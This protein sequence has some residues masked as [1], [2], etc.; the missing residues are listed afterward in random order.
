MALI[1][2]SLKGLATEQYCAKW[3][4][5]LNAKKSKNVSFGKKHSLAILKLDGKDIEWVDSWSNLGVTIK[6]HSSFNCCIDDKVKAFYRCAKTQCK[7]E[8][9]LGCAGPCEQEIIVLHRK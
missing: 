6:S 1:S 5:L 8:V 2:P 3:D 9:S 7:N 4:K